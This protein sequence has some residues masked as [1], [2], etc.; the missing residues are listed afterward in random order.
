MKLIDFSGLLQG[1]RSRLRDNTP[2]SSCGNVSLKTQSKEEF[3]IRIR[4]LKRKNPA[5]TLILIKALSKRIDLKALTLFISNLEFDE[6]QVLKFQFPLA[7]QPYRLDKAIWKNFIPAFSTW[8]WNNYYL[9][10]L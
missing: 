10:H 1:M 5:D 6:L 8:N 9:V 3:C 7:C 2:G 4:F